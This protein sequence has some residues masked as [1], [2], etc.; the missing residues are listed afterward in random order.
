MNSLEDKINQVEA[1][2][3]ERQSLL[4]DPRKVQR[5]LNH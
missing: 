2:V 3:I 1:W 5:S 4:H